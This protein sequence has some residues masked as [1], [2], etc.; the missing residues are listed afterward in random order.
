ML[1]EL[2]V[3]VAGWGLSINPFD[4]PNVQQAKDATR[5]V[6]DAFEASKRLDAPP[7]TGVPELRRLLAGASPHRS[8]RRARKLS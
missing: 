3:A 2:T 5:R 1:A 6:L 7:D 4:Q 8:T